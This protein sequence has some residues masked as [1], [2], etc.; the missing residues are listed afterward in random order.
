M[1]GAIC[2]YNLTYIQVYISITSTVAFSNKYCTLSVVGRVFTLLFFRPCNWQLLPLSFRCGTS[3]G[4]ESHRGYFPTEIS[5]VIKVESSKDHRQDQETI[6]ISG[7]T[8]EAP[9]A[10]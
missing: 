1:G 5:L 8:A 4:R 7:V 3:T 2:H 6:Y 10:I 9:I